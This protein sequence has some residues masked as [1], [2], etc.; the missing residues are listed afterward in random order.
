MNRLSKDHKQKLLLAGLA[1][2]V[3]IAGLWF[4]LI[5]AQRSGLKKLAA[6]KTSAL[7][8]LQQ[9]ETTV[10]NADQVEIELREAAARLAEFEQGVA[11]GDPYIWM[12]ETIRQFKAPHP[13][14]I[15]Q[16]S[17]I[18]VATNT[19]LPRF[20]YRQAT[21]TITGSGYYHD[22][23]RFVSDFENHY[24]QVRLQN[25]LIEQQ[26]LSSEDREKL[27]FKIDVIALIK[28]GSA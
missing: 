18:V 12:I 9:V 14:E 25:L 22:I 11:S 1:T 20:P 5:S 10:K 16:F 13:I 15:R 2:A 19:L 7:Q 4:T 17:P 8:K 26:P 28:S 3:T 6:E 27:F 21:M 24:P 23:G